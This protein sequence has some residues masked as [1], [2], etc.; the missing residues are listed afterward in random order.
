MADPELPAAVGPSVARH[1]R[2]AI[3]AAL[4]Q[5]GW[6]D[7]DDPDEADLL[8]FQNCDSC[9][10]LRCACSGVPFLSSLIW[11]QVDKF[12]DLTAA[13][14]A[15]ERQIRSRVAEELFAWADEKGGKEVFGPL[16]ARRRAI[17]SAARHIA[18]KPT[19]EE[20]AAAFKA[21]DFAGCYLDDAGRAIDP[22]LVQLQPDGTH[23]PAEPYRG[24]AM[25]GG[26]G[27]LP[28]GHEGECYQ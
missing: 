9:E 18:P 11:D 3:G 7:R 6:M 13:L 21:G 26:C 16:A 17:H 15:H 22:A 4:I 10:Q 24:P 8:Q 2:R 23:E 28:T 5:S 27:I 19:L 20:I 14:A 25:C 12:G 1:L